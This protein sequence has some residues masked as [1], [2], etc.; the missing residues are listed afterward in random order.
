MGGAISA[1]A[2][3]GVLSGCQ[4]DPKVDW[5]PRFF[6]TDEAGI[7]EAIAER[8]IPHTDTPGAKDAGVPAF[9][10]TMMAEF[11]QED[12]KKAFREGIKTV[13]TDARAAYGKSFV[14]LAPEQQDEL[15]RKYDAEAYDK[16]RKPENKH[17]FRMMKELTVLGF[18]TSEPG[19][20][21]FLKYDPAPGDYKG[22]IPYAEVGAAWA[23]S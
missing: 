9:I 17:F 5:T 14:S 16:E 2:M 15:L 1:S 10:D 4:A 22:C 20:T 11:Y 7:V 6:S 13:M 12:E 23:T 21:E 19:A 18:C 3:T 8:I